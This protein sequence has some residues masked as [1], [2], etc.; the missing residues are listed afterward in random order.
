[1][2]KSKSE[3]YADLLQKTCD[4]TVTTAQAVAEANRFRQAADGKAHPEWLLG[5]LASSLNTVVL[6]WMLGEESAVPKGFG[7]SFAPDF[8]GGAPITNKSQD[9]PSWD[10]VMQIYKVVSAKC[11]AGIRQIPDEDLT[12]PLKGAIPD[13]FREFFP[14]NEATISNMTLH[15]SYH[16]GQMSLLNNLPA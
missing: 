9:Y 12:K 11:I 7:R 15:D 2:S 13:Q 14:T 5:H 4:A 10:E 6:E 8:A 3:I 16:R 1:M